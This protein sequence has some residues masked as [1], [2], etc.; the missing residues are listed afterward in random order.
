MLHTHQCDVHN[1]YRTINTRQ[2]LTTIRSYKVPT[3]DHDLDFYVRERRDTEQDRVRNLLSESTRYSLRAEIDSMYRDKS[4]EAWVGLTK[5]L[6][7]DEK[8]QEAL[9]KL[10]RDAR[11]I[12]WLYGGIIFVYSFVIWMC[13][14][15][16]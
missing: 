6:E 2:P 15:T 11:I 7:A 16:W 12:V 1:S 4:L 13:I 8:H 14:L 5:A 9:E 10:T 3:I